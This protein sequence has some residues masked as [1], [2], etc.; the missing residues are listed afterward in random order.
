MLGRPGERHKRQETWSEA[1]PEG[2]WR[3]YSREE[4]VKRDKTSLDIFWLRDQSQGDLEN[5]PEPDDIAADIIE[6]LESGLESFRS[7]LSTLQA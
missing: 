3:R 4:I 2:R 7:V 1:N 6:N 5:L